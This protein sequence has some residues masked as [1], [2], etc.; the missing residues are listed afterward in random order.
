[1]RTGILCL[2]FILLVLCIAALYS[3]VGSCLEHVEPKRCVSKVYK[4]ICKNVELEYS[5][6]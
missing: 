6:K 3:N 1:M 5:S 2:S 4:Q